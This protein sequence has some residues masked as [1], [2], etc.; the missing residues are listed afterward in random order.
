MRLLRTSLVII[1]LTMT[2]CS[3]AQVCTILSTS[4]SCLSNNTVLPGINDGTSALCS[5]SAVYA[6]IP[7]VLGTLFIVALTNQSCPAGVGALA[8]N[9]TAITQ[10]A[11][12]TALSASRAAA[13]IRIT[14]PT[15]Q[16]LFSDSAISDCAKGFIEVPGTSTPAACTT[17]PPVAS[18]V[19]G[20][21]GACDQFLGT[22]D[23][24]APLQTCGDISPILI[25]TEGEGFHLTD[26]ANGA[27]FDIRGNGHPIQISWTAQGSHNAFLALP[28]LDGAVH[29]GKELFGNF[30]PQ[31]QSSTPNG[32]LA[33]EEWDK[34]ANGGNGDGIIDER[35]QVF[36][37]LR[38]WI[39][40][41]HD[42]VS[43]PAELHTLPELGVYSL[44]L[45]YRESGKTDEFGNQF[46][47]KGIVNPGARHDHRDDVSEAGR[48]E[49][50][51]FLTTK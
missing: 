35:D 16:L 41:N 51:V 4:G 15:P 39:D 25:D 14:N 45:H 34:P 46:R 3:S 26:A 50:D 2:Y 37:H 24:A 32:F 36:S 20:G 11:G 38:L 31:P 28:G 6:G 47:Y 21:G 29:S 44:S 7:D 13:V 19:G 27:V 5:T 18:L 23:G 10:Q 48:W 12:S 43:Q 40:S 17:D 30:S 49:Y 22:G 1:C 9:Q 33:L 42:G 8:V